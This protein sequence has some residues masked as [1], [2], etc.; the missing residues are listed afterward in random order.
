MHNIQ[1]HKKG[2]CEKST[3][4]VEQARTDKVD[5]SKELGFEMNFGGLVAFGNERTFKAWGLNK[6]GMECINKVGR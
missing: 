3:K 4:G 1:R 2:D 5:L 6:P